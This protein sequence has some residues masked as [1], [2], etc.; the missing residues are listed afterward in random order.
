MSAPL[1]EVPYFQ[2]VCYQVLNAYLR[3]FG[4]EPMS[5]KQNGI[6]NTTTA[7][8]SN[9]KIILDFSYWPED[10]PNYCV[11][12]GL[13]FLEGRRYLVDSGIGL[14]YAIPPEKQESWRFKTEKELNAILCHVRDEVLPTH[15]EALW[16]DPQLLRQL[17]T[18]FHSERD[19]KNESEEVERKRRQAE[20]AFKSGDFSEAIR[21]YSEFSPVDL[22]A[23]DQKRIEIA[24]K[25]LK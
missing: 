16:K 21:I 23:T 13:G 11:M 4:F 7:A 22:T 3:L 2:A 8:Y 25:K 20:A 9:D 1:V 24:R 19:A 14:W 12:I 6:E 18:R 15:A 10:F 5:V 17:I